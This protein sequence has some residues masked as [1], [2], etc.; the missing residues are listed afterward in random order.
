[1]GILWRKKENEMTFQEHEDRL[2]AALKD[3]TPFAY[4]KGVGKEWD[5][6]CAERSVY[7][8]Y[9]AWEA[10]KNKD[11]FGSLAAWAAREF[12]QGVY[13]TDA[14]KQ[15]EWAR[16]YADSAIYYIEANRNLVTRDNFIEAYKRNLDNAEKAYHLLSLH[17]NALLLQNMELRSHRAKSCW[18]CRL[19][20]T[21]ATFRGKGE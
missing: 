2:W 7:A 13:I 14:A 17:H 4:E 19:K 11:Y 16:K 21:V 6:L 10:A 3:H 18:W 9:D 12:L 5:R 1:M 15:E 8:A 20:Y